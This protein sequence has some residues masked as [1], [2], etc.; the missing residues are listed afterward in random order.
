LSA[1]TLCAT[2]AKALAM[3]GLRLVEVDMHELGELP[4]CFPF[5]QT[6]AAPPA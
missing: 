5:N 1:D 3:G 6:P 2:V 4:A